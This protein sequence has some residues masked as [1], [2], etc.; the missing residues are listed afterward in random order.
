MT[1]IICSICGAW[2]SIL[3]PVHPRVLDEPIKCSKCGT[4]NPLRYWALRSNEQIPG[5]PTGRDP[6]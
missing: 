4:P 1:L 6:A 2:R 5:M 3:T